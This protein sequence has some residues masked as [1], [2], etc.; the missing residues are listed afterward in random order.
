M[1]KAAD[2]QCVV[3]T[4]YRALYGILGGYIIARLAPNWPMRHAMVS[5]VLGL[6]AGIAGVIVTR[7][8]PIGPRWYPIDLAITASPCAWADAKLV[9]STAQ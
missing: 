1:R 5:G 4:V 7:D 9:R 8:R 6:I 2:G 3:A